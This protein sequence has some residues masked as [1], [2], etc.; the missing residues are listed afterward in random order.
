MKPRM[1]EEMDK[2]ADIVR[3]G[4]E[5][6]EFGSGGDNKVGIAK[7][8]KKRFELRDKRRCHSATE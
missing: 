3:G 4:Q 5:M 1:S 2:S 6:L 7:R 8:E